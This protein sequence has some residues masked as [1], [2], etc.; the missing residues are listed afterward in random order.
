MK[1]LLFWIFAM[2]LIVP[3]I[4]HAYST[5]DGRLFN[6]TILWHTGDFNT[7][8]DNSTFRHIGEI[9][10]GTWVTQT[11]TVQLGDKATAS[12]DSD[13]L[14]TY[15]N[16]PA[17]MTLNFTLCAWINYT[18]VTG[19]N[20]VSY[21]TSSAV[22]PKWKMAVNNLNTLEFSYLGS[23][24]EADHINILLNTAA[25]QNTTF[26]ACASLNVSD[27]GSGA[28]SV[29]TYLNGTE[30]STA[31]I[32]ASDTPASNLGVK[33]GKDTA[34]FSTGMT[35]I[36][37]FVIWN[38]S[39]TS[40]EIDNYYQLGRN[41]TTL[42]NLIEPPTLDTTA[43]TLDS[44]SM[45]NTNPIVNEVVGVSAQFTDETSLSSIWAAHNQSGVF[46]NFT[47]TNFT[48]TVTTGN[49]SPNLTATTEGAVV[50]FVFTANDTSGNV[51]QTIGENFT[52]Q[53]LTPPEI[54]LINLTSEVVGDGLGQLV[55]NV[56]SNIGKLNNTVRTNDTTP[57]IRA[58]TSESSTCAIYA[59]PRI[60]VSNASTVLLM[61]F[62]QN[63]SD[64]SQFGNDGRVIGNVVHNTEGGQIRGAFTF[65]GDDGMINVTNT[66]SLKNIFNKSGGATI[67]AW[68]NPF[69]KGESNDVR[70]L[71]KDEGSIGW[72]L[73]MG[74]FSGNN[75]D[76]RF[77]TRR[78]TTSGLWSTTSRE[79]T[80]NESQ[81]IAITYDGSSTT[82]NPVFYVNGVSV[83]ITE[84]VTP[85]GVQKDDS[86]SYL[87]I[88]NLRSNSQTFDGII[89]EVSI[90]DVALTAS[91]IK[92]H[93]QNGLS[94]NMNYSQMVRLIGDATT[95]ECSTTGGTGQICT[96]T[97][98]DTVTL[99]ETL[100]LNDARTG[101]AAGFIAC[102]D[103]S[104]NENRTSTSGMFYFNITDPIAPN[105]TL[106]VPEVDALFF[107]GIN[108]TN[109]NFTSFGIDNIDENFTLELLIDGVVQITNNTYLNG[110][111]VTYLLDVTTLGTHKWN[112]RLT[113]S[114]NNINVS[115]NR[116]FTVEQEETITLFIDGLAENRKYE[117][118]SFVNISANC[119][120]NLGLSCLV[121]ID[122]DA[123][124]FGINFSS[125]E[126]RTHFIFNITILRNN[127]FSHGPISVTLTESG[128][129]NVTSNNLTLMVNVSLNITSVGESTLNLSFGKL[130][131]TYR[132]TLKT[133]Y[134]EDNEFLHDNSYKSA[135]NLTFISAGSKLIFV[136]LSNNDY[137]INLT[138]D[139]SGFDL[140]I[141]NEFEY[142]EHFNDTDGAI[143]FNETWSFKIDA[144]LGY[145]EDFTDNNTAKWTIVDIVNACGVELLIGGEHGETDKCE[146]GGAPNN[147][148]FLRCD[149]AEES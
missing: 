122:L 116:S 49:F 99:E 103:T 86:N 63:A 47:S 92:D 11:D 72:F 95:R 2:I 29:I 148:L 14:I 101:I 117:Y 66:S 43:P 24:D 79:L 76:L 9:I 67:E 20:I 41:G 121:E 123:P 37:E 120:D 32:A 1:K 15:N 136:N 144:P 18:F 62:D 22:N 30:E 54:S 55:F 50:G 80:F 46:V 133:Q 74:D 31:S 8:D 91:E 52:V 110:T 61:T 104:A 143:G 73:F 19:R 3:V 28:A 129:L 42:L 124:G 51:L 125:G 38:I 134:L 90:W 39:L 58:I 16:I 26:L 130:D 137:P 142:I 5:T 139:I 48:G 141:D 87:F 111:N 34:L 126:N 53:D 44:V 102:K 89:D 96:V 105:S 70:I 13:G 131:R 135:V 7:T 69:R 21:Y 88:G 145:L 60:S 109:I 100:K 57:T 25:Y 68:I 84:D 98:N 36:Y 40:E 78:D 115:E 83:T 114:Y 118:R 77:G 147:C 113:D 108:N 27:S 82:N 94:P 146:G 4:A 128:T 132:G 56:S 97:E 85:S 23:A 17:Y 75:L 140:D 112:I 10:S 71:D 119:T 107:L 106:F 59:S 127:N 6:N 64:E 65:D 12:D 81:H 35:G 138:F 149:A 93:F 33:V 45:N